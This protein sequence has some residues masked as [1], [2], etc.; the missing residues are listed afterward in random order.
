MERRTF[1][2]KVKP[3]GII[4]IPL[5][6]RKKLKWDVGDEINLF[7]HPGYLIL[8]EKEVPEK[9]IKKSRALRGLV[10]IKDEKLV[11]RIIYSPEFEP[12]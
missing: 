5:E 7:L 4:E 11:K 3:N 9:K 6:V 10:K 1:R 12:I 8:E 2:E